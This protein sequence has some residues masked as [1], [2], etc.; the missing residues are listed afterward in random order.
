MKVWIVP[1]NW[2]RLCTSVLDS[3]SVVSITDVTTEN[4]PDEEQAL[5]STAAAFM[6]SMNDALLKL[7]LDMARVHVIK[8]RLKQKQD[9]ND[10]FVKYSYRFSKDL[11]KFER[12]ARR[13]VN[14]MHSLQNHSAVQNDVIRSLMADCDRLAKN[15]EEIDYWAHHFGVKVKNHKQVQE[16]AKQKRDKKKEENIAKEKRRKEK[17]GVQKKAK[18]AQK[19]KI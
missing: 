5:D 18:R 3:G 17:K 11:A 19:V 16:C 8:V 15:A 10:P 9:A 12:S 7:H 6:Q 13:P 2:Q 4:P 14:L 1:T